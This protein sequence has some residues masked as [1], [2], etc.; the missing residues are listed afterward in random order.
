MN[1]EFHAILMDLLKQKYVSLPTLAER[2]GYREGMLLSW[3]TGESWMPEVEVKRIIEVLA[4]NQGEL[5]RLLEAYHHTFLLHA[6]TSEVRQGIDRPEARE[7][8][9]VQLKRTQ[10]TIAS[11]SAQ[12][13]KVSRTEGNPAELAEE[14]S[15]LQTQLTVLQETGQ[16]LL[17][18]SVLPTADAILSTRVLIDAVNRIE[19]NSRAPGQSTAAIGLVAGIVVGGLINGVTGGQMTFIGGLLLTVLVL[20][21]YTGWLFFS[22]R[23]S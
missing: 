20:L 14:M 23:S 18:P 12:W 4:L 15:T 13:E 19:A 6:R 10:G 3:I 2:L 22:S 1:T 8:F 16:Q 21:M 5:E 17:A 9:E 7:R 11:I